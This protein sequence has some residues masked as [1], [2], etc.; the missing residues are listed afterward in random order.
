M[1]GDEPHARGSVHE[2]DG[3]ST[4]LGAGAQPVPFGFE[5][6]GEYELLMK[7]RRIRNELRH[8]SQLG[9]EGPAGHNVA[10]HNG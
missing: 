8:E 7:E 6:T 10:D 1:D 3:H 4:I 9:D 5:A 2:E